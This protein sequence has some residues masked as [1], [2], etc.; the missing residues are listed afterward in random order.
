ML[1]DEPAGDRCRK[2]LRIIVPYRARPE[3]IQKFVHFMYVARG[4]FSRTIPTM[5]TVR[6][7]LKPLSQYIVL[8][9]YLKD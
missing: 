8:A 9:D 4:K 5:P 7:S 1:L 2:C 3:H 6:F